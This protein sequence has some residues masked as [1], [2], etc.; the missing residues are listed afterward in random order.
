MNS[1]SILS[2][3]LRVRLKLDPH[4]RP[5]EPADGDEIYP[6]G[7]FE[8]NITRLL[9]FIEAHR[10]QFAVELFPV[11]DIPEY[12]SKQVN[13]ETICAAD[14][15]RPILRAEIA[16]SRFNV[17][18]GHH[19]VTRARRESVAFLPALTIH[20]PQHVP[21]LISTEAYEKYVEY[22]NSKL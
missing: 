2:D 7:I 21:F 1:E 3:P 22:W 8:F 19:R 18:D 16:P 6:N 17:I 14:L 10:E 5:C 13:E 20:C 11:S 9:C 12:G 4:F 15:S